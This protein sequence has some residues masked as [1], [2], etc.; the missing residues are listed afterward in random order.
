MKNKHWYSSAWTMIG[1]PT[2]GFLLTIS[3]DYLKDKPILTTLVSIFSAIWNFLYSLLNFDLKVWWIL[4]AILLFVGVIYLIQRFQNE[5]IN[6]PEFLKY[7]EDKF[8]SWTWTWE[9]NW[10]ERNQRWM[11]VELQPNCPT[12]GTTLMENSTI[13]DTIYECPRGDFKTGRH[14]SPTEDKRNIEA[15]IIDKIKKQK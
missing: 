13:Y 1:G 4:I 14:G 8:K 12:C 7:K 2:F 9:W 11:I 6:E 5:E 15:L 3:R 10:N